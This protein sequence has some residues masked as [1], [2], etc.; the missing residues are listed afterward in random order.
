MTGNQGEET[1]G[2]E[3][4][5]GGNNKA[6]NYSSSWPSSLD[7]GS[8][9]RNLYKGFKTDRSS[10]EDY[11]PPERVIRKLEERKDTPM[12]LGDNKKTEKTGMGDSKHATTKDVSATPEVTNKR[13]NRF[14]RGSVKDSIEDEPIIETQITLPLTVSYGGSSINEALFE[15]IG[16]MESGQVIPAV[17]RI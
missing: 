4:K 17:S 13:V 12:N 7:I 16:E 15:A 5:I 9:E 1:R 6:V 2:R 8:S 14:E 10:D 3:I 11:S